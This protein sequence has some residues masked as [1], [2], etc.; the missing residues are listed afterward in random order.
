M[1]VQAITRMTVPEFLIWAEG[2]EG[3]GYELVAWVF[4]CAVQPVR[5]TE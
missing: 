5:L 4:G 3:A 1:N 2:R